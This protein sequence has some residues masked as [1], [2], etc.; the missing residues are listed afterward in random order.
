MP[1]RGR[2][3]RKMRTEDRHHVYAA[4]WL[5]A[6]LVKARLQSLQDNWADRLPPYV[7]T[8]L[9]E[10]VDVLA[11]ALDAHRRYMEEVLG[12]VTPPAEK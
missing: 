6:V 3:W 7:L 8:S 10:M 1:R 12:P 11:A 9:E 2:R 4:L 5:A